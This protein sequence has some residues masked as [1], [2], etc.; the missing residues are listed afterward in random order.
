MAERREVNVERP[1]H[2]WIPLG[3]MS[4]LIHE[5]NRWEDP[6]DPRAGYRL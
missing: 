5:P 2:S 3:W 4:E 1:E 6:K